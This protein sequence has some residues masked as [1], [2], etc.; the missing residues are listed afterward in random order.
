MPTFAPYIIV[1]IF[2]WVCVLKSGIHATL[3]GIIV[4]LSIPLRTKNVSDHSPAISLE[5]K[6]HPWVAY[7]ILPIFAFAN[8]GIPLKGFS[9]DMLRHPITMGIALG[10]FFGKQIGIMTM[11]IIGV[12][13]KKCALPKGV[14]WKQFYAMSLLTGIG[15][16]MSLF[17]GNLAF[18][19]AHNKIFIRL[20][21]IFGSLLSGIAGYILLKKTCPNKD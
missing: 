18:D 6:L 11:T 15:F 8:A 19:N 13:I 17:I 3:A 5:H 20:G 16:T 10:L 7:G 12:S 4:A 2:L 21:V 14:T 1:G 9:L